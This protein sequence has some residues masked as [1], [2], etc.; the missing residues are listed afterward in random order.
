M[1][2]IEA[3]Q[4]KGAGEGERRGTHDRLGAERKAARGLRSQ[5]PE[6]DCNECGGPAPTRKA[7]PTPDRPTSRN[8]SAAFF[9]TLTPS[10]TLSE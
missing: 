9:N 10:G 1:A 4:A 8:P 7:I 2:R 3:V 5:T 6:E